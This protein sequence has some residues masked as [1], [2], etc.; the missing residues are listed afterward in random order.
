MMHD[1]VGDNFTSGLIFPIYRNAGEIRKG[2]SNQSKVGTLSG[3]SSSV[4]FTKIL[5]LTYLQQLFVNHFSMCT[6]VVH[7]LNI[8]LLTCSLYC[9]NIF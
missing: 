8:L 6:K 5:V 1:G 9:V 2:Y 3:C 7:V 4:S